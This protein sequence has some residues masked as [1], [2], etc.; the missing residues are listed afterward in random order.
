MV[1]LQV[2]SRST[3]RESAQPALP[4]WV[5]PCL[6]QASHRRTLLS[7]L[8]SKISGPKLPEVSSRYAGFT[9]VELL[10]VVAIVAIL[11]AFLFPVF[12]RAR[13]RARQ[14]AC[15]SNLRQLALATFQYAQ[16]SD[17]HYPYGGDPS[18]LD[19]TSW[20]YWQQGKYW[21]DILQMQANHQSLPNVMAGYIKDT[22][23]WECPDDNGFK[24]GGS[25]EDLPLDA[26]SSCFR[27]FGMSYIYTTPLALDAQTVGG[28]RAWSRL[29]PYSEH[30]PVD[31]PL[32]SDHVGHWHGGVER[33][34]ERLNMVMV[35][36]H[37]ISVTRDRADTLN[38]ILF[39]IPNG[40]MP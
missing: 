24:V 26:G 18:D 23:I 28:V 40:P 27:T 15:L 37:A 7:S 8:P 17:D 19:T 1:Q 38:R 32:F 39:T 30:D 11:A 2:F 12:S 33:S 13:Q 9:L 34:E 22:R 20:Q 5:G 6:R 35:D 16:D 25:F 36:G 10:V 21:P 3:S 29:P 31:V 4:V 14:T